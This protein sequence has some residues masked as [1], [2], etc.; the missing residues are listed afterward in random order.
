MKW[1]ETITIRCTGSREK[2]VVMDL[3]QKIGKPEGEGWIT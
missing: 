3:L 2:R 1:L